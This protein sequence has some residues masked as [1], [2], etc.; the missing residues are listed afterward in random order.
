MTTQPGEESEPP[1]PKEKRLGLRA[2]GILLIVAAAWI[3]LQGLAD[4]KSGDVD[5]RYNRRGGQMA[6]NASARAA[7]VL[8]LVGAICVGRSIPCKPDK[9]NNDKTPS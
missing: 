8:L 5:V 4:I 2:L 1:I 7:F 6:S 9:E 3:F